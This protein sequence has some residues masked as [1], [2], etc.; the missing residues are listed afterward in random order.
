M[1]PLIWGKWREKVLE[2]GVGE[3]EVK[4]EDDQHRIYKDDAGTG[5]G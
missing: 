5:A 3:P 4:A 1:L 2:I